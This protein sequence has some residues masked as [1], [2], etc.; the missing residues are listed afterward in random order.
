MFP[1][2]LF[3]SV[4]FYPDKLVITFDSQR[5]EPRGARAR[6]VDPRASGLGD[7]VDCSICVQVCPTGIDI[8]NGL[9]YECIGC[10]AC[11]DSC[12]QVM[13]KMGY[14]PGLIRYTTENALARGD[15][16]GFDLRQL[17]RPR[18][19]V[20]TA[21]LLVLIAAFVTGLQ[22]RNPLKVDVIRDRSTLVRDTADGR[23]ENVYRLQIMNTTEQARRFAI[24]ASGLP[25]LEVVTE[26]PVR[27]E[28]ATT[29]AVV[30][31]VRADP[32]TVAAGSHPIEFH[33]RDLDDP[34]LAVREGSRMFVK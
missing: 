25:G 20:Y 6:K 31:A 16:A 7:C 33:V 4:I 12:N 18:V 13:S 26:Q 17:A 23:V 32:Q 3:Q 24:A 27:I 28:A 1:Y 10:G 15:T 14:A 5:G 11:I 9:Q 2:A 21:L 19:L 29:Q 22:M 30:V 34:R 8:R